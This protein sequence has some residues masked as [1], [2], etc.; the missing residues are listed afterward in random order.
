M[1]NP[2]QSTLSTTERRKMVAKALSI[3]LLIF[4]LINLTSQPLGFLVLILGIEEIW[5]S[6]AIMTRK[7]SAKGVARGAFVTFVIAITLAVGSIAIINHQ[8]S[9]IHLGFSFWD[10]IVLGLECGLLAHLGFGNILETEQDQDSE[11]AKQIV[12]PQA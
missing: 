5:A 6:I 10:V 3:P 9:P 2:A 4:G 11:G 7:A 8:D 1:N 12:S